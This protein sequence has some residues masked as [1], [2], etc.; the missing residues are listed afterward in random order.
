MSTM[1]PLRR[2]LPH[3]AST[4]AG[5][6]AGV[7][8]AA[9]AVLPLRERASVSGARVTLA[10]VVEP[11][12]LPSH[13]WGS[14]PVGAA[15]G[16]G[17]TVELSRAMIHS[18]L[19]RHLG[20]ADI[21]WDGAT[22]VTVSRA[23]RELTPSDLR[24]FLVRR[25]SGALGGVEGVEVLEMP[26]LGAVTFPEGATSLEIDLPAG[27][28]DQRWLQVTVRFTAGSRTLLSRHVQLRWSYP[29]TAWRTTRAVESGGS[30]A[31]GSLEPVRLDRFDAPPGAWGSAT[32]P[33]DAAAARSLSAG[34]ILADRDVTQ[35]L[36][37]R[38]G[39]PVTVLHE[40]GAAE[41]R[42]Q[43]TAVADGTRNA[44]IEVINPTSRRRIPVEVI[45]EGLCRYAP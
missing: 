27:F 41:V 2:S 33:A 18:A 15:P 7:L 39:A 35:R 32:I 30:L 45:E 8:S 40:F 10:D 13:S 20:P 11:S 36:L 5:V 3:L 1:R 23:G 14:V 37:V 29:V 25:L 43:G 6:F 31:D 28:A 22:S 12:S 9:S 21:T 24:A 42:V 34:R 44:R 38:R 4:L 17:Q 26:G 19:R 16:P